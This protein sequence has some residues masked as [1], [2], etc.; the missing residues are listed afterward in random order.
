MNTSVLLA[1]FKRNFVSYFANPTGYLFICVFVLMC[2]ASAFWPPDFF[3]NNLA[4]L[5]QLSWGIQILGFRFGFS[6]IMLVFVPSITMGIWAEERSQGTDELLLTIPAG[7]LEIV[8][9]KYLAAVAIFSVSLL[10]SL[11][12]NFAVL[13]W[14]G[15][16]DVGL[17]LGTYFGYWLVGLAMLAIG[18]AASFLTSNLTVSYIL[19]VLFNVPLVFASAAEVLI[20]LKA[21]APL[22]NLSIGEQFSDFG[23]GL[24][25]LSGI[26]YFVSIV[27]VMLYLSMVLI[28]RRH[29]VTGRRGGGMGVHYSLRF[30]SLAAIAVGAIIMFERHDARLDVTSEQLSSLAPQTKAI[31][32]DLKLQ[33]PVQIDAFISPE[34]PEAYVQA[35]LNL[36]T[37]LREFQALGKGMIRVTV[38]NAEPLS[39]E[40]ALAEKRFGIEPRKVPTKNHGV[41]SFDNIFMGVAV[42]SG[43]EKV[44]LP[45]IDRGIPFEYELVRSL[46]TVTQE[47]RKRIG[48]LAT[49]AQVFGRFNPMNPGASGNWPIIDELEKQYEVVQVNPAQPISEKYDVLLA[50]QPSTL[51]PD[52]MN[53]FIA[54]VEN[55]QPTAIF[56]DPL[57]V[58]AA[59][60][61][62]TLMPKRPP[63]GMEAM[64]MG[65]RAQPKGDIR[66]LWSLL[67]IDFMASNIVWQDYNPYPKTSQFPKEFV[68]IDKG[69]GNAEPFG[70]ESN[71]SSGLQQVLFPFPGAASKLNASPADLKFAPL[72]VTG[73]KTGAVAMGEVMQ[74]TPF[75]PR[76]LNENRRLA[77]TSAQYVLAA[78]ITGKIKAPRRA[79]D[80]K[81]E[82]NDGQSKAGDSAGGEKTAK[83]AAAK[84]GK[85]TKPAQPAE[86]NLHVVLVADIDMLSEDF[87]RLREM[88]D[89]P[90]NEINFQF[91]NVT[92]VLNVLDKLAG[93]ERFI[94]IRKRRAQHRI[95]T[96]IDQK[97]KEAQ[98]EA[99]KAQEKYY[100]DIQ[101]AEDDE[102]KAVADKLS[103][104]QN[105][106]DVDQMQLLIEVQMLQDDLNRKMEAKLNRIK[107][108]KKEEYNKIESNL[109]AQKR[110]YQERYKMMAVILPPIPPLL[111]AIAVF[112]RRR[113][114]E[115]EGVAKTRLR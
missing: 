61:P 77:P 103:E 46:G 43:L 12:C 99:A 33:H 4:N 13:K 21:A 24:I 111:V 89:T 95:L 32:A 79:G 25:S 7:D 48:V 1:V 62:G 60:V 41:I 58:F 67:G 47:K 11:V 86:T 26:V 68:F 88:G 30:F 54:A 112:T 76:G 83:D 115:R 100:N 59:N 6:I 85:E 31:L 3:N 63:G 56:E 10:F 57:P 50:V 106:K 5:D 81:A 73:D 84:D 53:N 110:R 27:V 96:R 90:E 107:K 19:G 45:F 42:T 9:G 38:H 94:E 29:W 20:G 2:S 64:M 49:D 72:A 105:R 104:L 113:K 28:G 108:E 55:G 75:G 78:E 51:G 109:N 35:R 23:H 22:K 82:K 44:I 98:K 66:P 40:A 65:M 114:R 69:E 102:K 92:F 80:E 70:T 39:D 37:I 52:E 8:L 36:L 97:T 87:F 74:M 91:D 18:M 71:I 17:F 16:P 93:D 101:K 34:V 14:L 15:D